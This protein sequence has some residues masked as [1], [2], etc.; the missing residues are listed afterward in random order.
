LIGPTG[1]AG[2]QGL[3]GDPGPIGMTGPAGV[4]VAPSI[5]SR[6]AWSSAIAYA[7][8]DLVYVINHVN[9]TDVLCQYLALAPSQGVSPPANA[10]PTS[11]N[12]VW[13]AFESGCRS[14]PTM[15]SLAPNGHYYAY[16]QSAIALT[17]QEAKATAALVAAPAAN[18]STYLATVTSQ[19]ERDFISNLTPSTAYTSGKWGPWL[20]AFQD[21]NDPTF[22]EPAGGW[23]W[24]TGE[25][26]GYTAWALG[27]PNSPPGVS[28]DFL[29]L[30]N[31]MP[32]SPVGSWND[33]SND[34]VSTYGSSYGVYGFILEASPSNSPP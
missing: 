1:V 19:A 6:G 27:E 26:W 9:Q 31:Y 21:R 34:P 17:W 7:T 8:F 20:G 12:N 16:V 11:A 13:L 24:V 15:W 2:P 32:N 29:H 33:Y 14:I 25:P 30:V 22:S 18:Y 3:K 28:E 4:T 10:D 23:H 5:S